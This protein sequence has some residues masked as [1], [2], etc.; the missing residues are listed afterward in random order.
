MQ[1]DERLESIEKA[2]GKFTEAMQIYAQ[3]L[4]S[5]TS[6]VINLAEVARDLKQSVVEQNKVLS[7]FAK[8][9]N[10]MSDHKGGDV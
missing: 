2:I 5:H 4:E 6:A 10:E 3:H 9:V 1:N 8:A 7:E